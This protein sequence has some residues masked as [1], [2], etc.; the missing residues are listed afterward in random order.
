MAADAIMPRLHTWASA[1]VPYPK[2]EHGYRM[3]SEEDARMR[4]LLDAGDP[5][6]T[7]RG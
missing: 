4:A 2:P 7:V 1:P 6:Y 3:P 5:P